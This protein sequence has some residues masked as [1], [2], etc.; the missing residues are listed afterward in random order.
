VLHEQEQQHDQG[1]PDRA[2][3]ST[4]VLPGADV[5]PALNSLV[6]KTASHPQVP[7][8]IALVVLLF[9]LV[10]HRIDRRDPKLALAPRESPEDLGFGSP[11]SLA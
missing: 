4:G 5:I 6:Q 9:L 1:D 11:I 7:V 2:S 10:Q 3:Q 8:G